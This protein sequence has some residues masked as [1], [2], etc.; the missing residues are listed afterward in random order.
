VSILTLRPEDVEDL[1][2]LFDVVREV[3]PTR[4]KWVITSKMLHHLLPNLI[5]PMDNQ[6]TAPFLGRGSL[7]ATF[8]ASFLV[9]SSSAFVDLAKN[10]RYGIGARRVRAVA[11]EVPYQVEGAAPDDCRIGVARV[12]DFAVAGFVR[13]HGRAELKSL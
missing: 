9:E 3:K 8:E 6:M 5:V 11:R 4:R 10:R 2:Q 1:F 13:D 12:V 7:P